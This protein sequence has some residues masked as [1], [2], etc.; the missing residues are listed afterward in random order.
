MCLR[1]P[2]WAVHRIGHGHV[3]LSAGFML[4][5]HTGHHQR[6]CL[7]QSVTGVGYLQRGH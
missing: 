6:L 7:S 3:L 4:Q 2:A 5:Q 1:C